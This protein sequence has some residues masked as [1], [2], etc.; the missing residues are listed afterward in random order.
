MTPACCVSNAIRGFAIETVAGPAPRRYRCSDVFGMPV[1]AA[2]WPRVLPFG[3]EE[4]G[5][6]D[7][8][9]GVGDGPADAPAG[10]FGDGAGVGGAFGG[11][12]AFHLGEQRQQQ[13]GDAAHAFVGGVDRQRV[14]QGAHADAAARQGRGRG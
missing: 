7:L 4:S 3:L 13:E 9:F 12:G 10:G 5:V 1:L 6:L 8:V 14:G 11:E 2:I